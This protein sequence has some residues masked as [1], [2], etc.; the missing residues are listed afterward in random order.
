MSQPDSPTGSPPPPPPPLADLPSPMAARPS[1]SPSPPAAAAAAPATPAAAAA[2]SPTSP[3]T[4]APAVSTTQALTQQLQQA[5]AKGDL[6]KSLEALS[7]LLALSGDNRLKHDLLLKL[8]ELT[9]HFAPSL[10]VVAPAHVMPLLR[11]MRLLLVDKEPTL[12]SQALRVLRY[13]LADWTML[14]HMLTLNLDLLIVRSLE[15]ESKFLWERMQALK[16]VRK[17]M[18]MS[19][20]A[21]VAAKAKVGAPPPPPDTPPP[22]PQHAPIDLTRSLVQSLVSIAEQ[23]KDDFRRVCL[24]A[25]REL[26]Q[27]ISIFHISRRGTRLLK[28]VTRSLIIPASLC[29]AV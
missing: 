8:V 25:I 24:D 23:P 9:R 20:A 18:G 15:R 27:C 22:P 3:S 14:S 12:R 13:L 2:V 4:A 29:V 5:L 10:A 26:S 7:S 17:W 28:R 6:N 21:Q 1:P 11:C 19:S 16:F